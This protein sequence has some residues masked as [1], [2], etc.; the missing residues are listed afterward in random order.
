VFPDLHGLAGVGEPDGGPLQLGHRGGRASSTTDGA[1]GQS[2]CSG[3]SG[4]GQS[5]RTNFS[6]KSKKVVKFLKEKRIQVL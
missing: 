3:S 1:M 4:R 2:E 6:G 5:H